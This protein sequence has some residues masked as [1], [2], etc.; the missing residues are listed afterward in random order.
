MSVIFQ[1]KLNAATDWLL[2]KA[3][4]TM[5]AGEN[6]NSQVVVR[7]APRSLMI[8]LRIAGRNAKMGSRHPRCLRRAA[9]KCDAASR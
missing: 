2:R 7:D 4:Y 9:L 5:D 1:P 3:I 8:S 6:I